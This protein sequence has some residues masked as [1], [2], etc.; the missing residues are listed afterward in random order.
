MPKSP[1]AISPS[2]FSPIFL[3]TDIS[4]YM[5][6]LGVNLTATLIVGAFCATIQSMFEL[7]FAVG[8]RIPPEQTGWQPMKELMKRNG[9]NCT[10]EELDIEVQR[11]NLT[12]ELVLQS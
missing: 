5:L 1:V 9:C 3:V 10:I 2:I 12:Y 7:W 6:R 4:D 8:V 11:A